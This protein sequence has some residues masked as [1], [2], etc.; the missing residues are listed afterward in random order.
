[1][2]FTDL[3]D[4]AVMIHNSS[5]EQAAVS[6]TAVSAAGVAGTPTEYE[7]P[8]GDS[9]AVSAEQLDS[10]GSTFSV[11]VRSDV[12]VVVERLLVF[13]DPMDLSLQASVPV[14]DSLDGLADLGG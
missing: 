10:S 4:G 9:V 12:P 8:A 1:M 14:L 11:V 6:V 5:R 7:I 2:G 13:R 3:L